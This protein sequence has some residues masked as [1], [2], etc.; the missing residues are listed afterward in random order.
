V[1]LHWGFPMSTDTPE[2]LDQRIARL[3]EQHNLVTDTPDCPNC[4]EGPP[5][6]DHGPVTFCE[7]CQN[8]DDGPCDVLVLVAEVEQLTAQVGDTSVPDCEWT[9][10]HN[11][12]TAEGAATTDYDAAEAA[13]AHV[14]AANPGHEVVLMARQVTGWAAIAESSS[15]KEKETDGRP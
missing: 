14:R 11:D 8:E 10:R 7:N 12:Y 3:R 15:T 6:C 1:E 9:W 2:Q 5:W 13:A 4:G